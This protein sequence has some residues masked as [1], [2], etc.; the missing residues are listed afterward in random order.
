MLCMNGLRVCKGGGS[1]PVEDRAFGQ[2]VGWKEHGTG[3]QEILVCPGSP[4]DVLSQLRKVTSLV[5]VCFF[6]H[7]IRKMGQVTCR[8]TWTL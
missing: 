2:I 3:A 4:I 5:S 8:I 1:P 7:K 6:T